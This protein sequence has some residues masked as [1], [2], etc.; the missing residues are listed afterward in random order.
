MRAA[1]RTS[2]R[3]CRRT[4]D[5][6]DRGRGGRR[7]RSSRSRPAGVLVAVAGSGAAALGPPRFV[8]ETA[9][10]G[11][12]DVRRAARL[13]RRRR[14]R[15]PRLRRRRP[16]GPVRR[17]RR[18]T[19]RR[20]TA[21]TSP[22]AARCTSSRVAGPATDLDRRHGRLPDRHRRRRDRRPRRPPRSARTSCSAGSGD[23]RF[24]RA[25]ER[26]SFDGGIAPTMAF[27][28]T[29]E[30]AASPADPR[31]RQLRRP[32][33]GRTIRT[34][35]CV[36]QRPASG[37]RRPARPTRRPDPLAPGFCALSMLFSDWDGSGRRDLR[38][39]N[40]RHYY[41]DGEEQLW[42]I[43]PGAA[44]RLYTAAE[45]WVQ[46]QRRGHGHRQLRPDR[47]RPTRGLPDEPGREPAP[48]AHRR[49]GQADATATSA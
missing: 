12:P 31:L 34:A 18:R 43:E 20:S 22:S 48:D 33:R 10:P 38:I 1:R 21:T 3:A 11:S 36:R 13:L 7:G 8:D 17:R 35:C 16:P 40:D 25:N 9:S 26:W 5:R 14:R 44:P 37:R 19:R 41:V 32:G 27:S 24:E 42:R 39:S 30:G 28:A 4:A 29:W 6:V 15:G 47:R 23:C 46:V 2:G 45:G 49:P